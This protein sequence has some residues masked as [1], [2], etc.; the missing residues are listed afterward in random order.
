MNSNWREDI[1]YQVCTYDKWDNNSWEKE[2]IEKTHIFFCKMCVPLQLLQIA[3]NIL[4]FW[5]HFENQPR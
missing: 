2:V 5:I 4:K 1:L 3:L